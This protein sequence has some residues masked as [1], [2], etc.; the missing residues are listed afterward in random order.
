VLRDLV[1]GYLRA[2]GL[3]VREASTGAEA[4]RLLN[5]TRP[6]LVVLDLGLPDIPGESVA[7]E[8]RA[9]DI[10]MLMLT[11]RATEAD[12]IAGLEAGAE[13]YVTK[14]FSP[15]ELV[16][17]AQALLRR[18]AATERTTKPDE[19]PLSYGGGALVIDT[20]RHSL[21]VRDQPVLLTPAEWNLLVALSGRPGQVRSR[22]SLAAAVHQDESE[23]LERTIDSHVKNLRRKVE[24]DPA[25][26]QIIQTV[27]GTGYRFGLTRDD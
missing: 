2:E 7:R 14:P 19:R 27:Q 20:G 21:L 26:P 13:D 24:R 10:P 11:A 6:D 4:L 9:Q 15:R 18:T 1:G 5:S 25:R 12:R 16:L 22:R 8:L 17:R 23:S 3:T